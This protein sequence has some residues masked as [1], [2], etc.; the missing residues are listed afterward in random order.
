MTEAT[1]RNSRSPRSGPPG[2]DRGRAARLVG[3]APVAIAHRGGAKLRPENTLVAFAH[4]LSVGVDAVECD[5]RLSKDGQPVV[6]H[7][8]T[9]DRTTNRTGLVSACTA[10]ELGD[11]D[12][13]HH[14]GPADGFPFRARGV[15][16]PRLAEVFALS[17]D[18]P[19]IVEIKGD[20]VAA[21]GPV[22]D[23]IAAA[24]AADR[25]VIGGFSHAVLTAVRRRA[26][27]IVTSASQSEVISALRW[28]YVWRAPRRPAFQLI[29][30]PLQL[31]GRRV[32]NRSL[33]RVL[34]RAGLPVQAW[35]VDEIDDMR[36]VLDW[37]VTGLI[38]DRPDRAVEVIR[39]RTTPRTES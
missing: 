17:A 11:V 14:F 10:E 6:I 38:S 31:R 24:G 23:A 36:R 3:S 16:V 34:R 35:I 21:V 22:L 9:L 32:L 12:A 30:A 5:V 13:G 15:G 8:E 20:D 1:Y 39:A 18:V 2:I 29:Q 25:V 26:P 19:L 33:V 7:D 37:G 4:A 27:E 28:S